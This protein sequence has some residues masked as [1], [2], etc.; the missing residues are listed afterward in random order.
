M[1][2]HINST[3]GFSTFCEP[4]PPPPPPLTRG[5]CFRHRLSE[6]GIPQRAHLVGKVKSFWRNCTD[7]LCEVQNIRGI[8]ASFIQTLAFLQDLFGQRR[9]CHRLVHFPLGMPNR[10]SNEGHRRCGTDNPPPGGRSGPPGR[11]TGH[12][13]LHGRPRRNDHPRRFFQCRLQS[14]LEAAP[15]GALTAVVFL[16]FFAHFSFSFRL[17]TSRKLRRALA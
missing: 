9:F 3:P 10:S 8:R 14:L 2:L 4:T 12:G 5:G 16:S 1:S 17:S 6:C 11:S 7:S 13:R 15:R